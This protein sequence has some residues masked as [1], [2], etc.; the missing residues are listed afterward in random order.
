MTIRTTYGNREEWLVGRSHGL[1]ASDIGVV[2]GVSNF[3]TPLQLW[4]EKV[5]AVVPKDISDNPRVQF[6]N[7]AEEPLRGMFRLMHPEYELSFEPYTILRQEGK[8][9]FL[10]CTPDGEL[11]EKATGRR[12]IYESKTGTCLSRA[13]WAKWDH[14][15]PKTYYAQ[16]L[17]QMFAGDFDF[18]VVWALLLN[19]ENDAS[20]RFYQFERSDREADIQYIL[21]KAEEFWSRVETGTMPAQILNF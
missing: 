20:L 17:E 7:D 3:K 15:I 16:I 12:G 4:K 6:G 11:V 14:Q 8:Y 1:G 19:A 2:L 10:T 21:P 5:G 13:D 18:A 9:G